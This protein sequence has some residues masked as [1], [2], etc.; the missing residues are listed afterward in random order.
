MKHAIVAPALS[1]AQWAYRNMPAFRDV[2]RENVCFVTR[3][4][5]IDKLRGVRVTVHVVQSERPFA[6]ADVQRLHW[7]R[8]LGETMILVH[9]NPNRITFRQV[10][11]P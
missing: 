8:V 1:I 4:E 7:E 9:A 6:L 3:Q 2:G 10:D 11:M 5:D